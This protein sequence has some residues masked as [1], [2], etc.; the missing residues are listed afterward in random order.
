MKTEIAANVIKML[1]VVWGFAILAF[2]YLVIKENAKSNP[3]VNLAKQ[4]KTHN[5]YIKYRSNIFI[6]GKFRLI[7]KQF[8]TFACYDHDKIERETV[9]VFETSV[10]NSLLI[11]VAT[12]VLLKDIL[13]FGLACIIGYI[14]FDISVNRTYDKVLRK[15]HEELSVALQSIRDN[16]KESDNIPKA[17]N[18]CDKGTMLEQPLGEIH[19]ILTSRDGEERLTHF[20]SINPV[21]LVK[22]LATTCHIVNEMGDEKTGTSDS[23]FADDMI[24]LRKEADSEVR[25]LRAIETA[26]KTMPIIC[27]MGLFIL[28]VSEMYLLNQIPGTSTLLKGTYGVVVKSAIILITA[29]VYYWISVSMRPSVV[30]QSDRSQFF[31]HMLLHRWFQKIVM[32]VI[33]KDSKTFD[34]VTRRIEGALS[35]K[36]IQYIYAQKI[37]YSCVSFCAGL[38]FAIIFI[39]TARSSLYNNYKSLSFIDTGAIREETYRHIKAMDTEYLKL[40]EPVTDDEE[41]LKYV[42]G[43]LRGLNELDYINQ[44]DRLAKKYELYHACKW[45]WPWALVPIL[46]SL[47]CWFIP[48]GTLTL[49][50]KMVD[51]EA[52]EDVMQL[53]T[54]MI[55]LSATNMDAFKALYW[56]E[57]QASVN[58]EI[59]RYCFHEY[60]SDPL[61]ALDN[62]N[63]KT[64]NVEFHKIVNKLKLSSTSLSLYDAFGDMLLDKDQYMYLRDQA[65]T[66]ALESRRSTGR[67]LASVPPMLALIGYFVA[68]ILI[69]GVTQLMGSMGGL[70]GS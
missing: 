55:V 22:T 70:M 62:L 16:Y 44:R 37:F 41:L 49:R 14:Y 58:K 56:L 66:V 50:K 26:F 57:K 33:P 6:R 25:R 19:E 52:A 24:I 42:K 27:L 60:T 54:M 47:A 9:E 69:L 31:D 21:R 18:N 11:P 45:N 15:I 12:G 43:R 1:A 28:P 59:L 3:K 63:R 61:T 36:D 34:K 13:M 17:I 53:Q 64:T 32:D 46:A 40:E 10:R 35:Q 38:L 4:Q 23:A 2:V 65:Q 51:Y 39:I 67:L 48:E 7:E 68:P 5:R 20:C 8:A 30:N 29:V